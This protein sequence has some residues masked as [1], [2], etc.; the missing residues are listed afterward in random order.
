MEAHDLLS[1]K[2][3][4]SPIMIYVHKNSIQSMRTAFLRNIWKIND[5][6]A[7]RHPTY[8]RI[9]KLRR[10]ALFSKSAS[11]LSTR[12]KR[13]R[14]LTL[15]WITF[16]K[17]SQPYILQT[18]SLLKFIMYF[19]WQGLRY[20]DQSFPSHFL[21]LSVEPDGS[22]WVAL[23]STLVDDKF[24]ATLLDDKSFLASVAIASRSSSTLDA[25]TTSH[26]S[27]LLG[28]WKTI[29]HTRLVGSFGFLVQI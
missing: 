5:D 19:Y 25:F 24:S 8:M 12:W 6:R 26:S 10:F 11:C 17:Y 28:A 21:Y 15:P 7:N 27:R 18:K 2:C 9:I 16:H 22:S 29:L 13:E 3:T 4:L 23:F 20:L 14:L 1:M